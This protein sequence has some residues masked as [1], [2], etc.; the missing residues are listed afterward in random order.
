MKKVT[1]IVCALAMIFGL[2]SCQPDSKHTYAD[3]VGLW[4]VERIEYFNIDYAGDPI[5]STV[6]V[7]DFTLGDPDDGIDI[8]FTDKKSGEMR[9]RDIDTF[10]VKVSTNPVVYDTIINP[11]T[12]VVISFKYTFD[13]EES[14]LV[15]KMED[16][17]S[18]FMMIISDFTND[19]FVYFNE[20]KPNAVEKA[21]LRRLS[22]SEERSKRSAGK[23]TYRIRKPGSFL[24]F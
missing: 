6:E 22:S 18:T 3:F 13:E 16:D 12:T 5:P 4:G 1:F 20:Y 11:D 21:Y 23:P 14:L 19:S 10:Y 15:M 9:R 8:L 7:Q 17:M 2:A 24:S